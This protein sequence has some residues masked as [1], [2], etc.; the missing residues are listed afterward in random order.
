M[1]DRPLYEGKALA[2]P[3]SSIDR[4]YPSR[5]FIAYLENS[6]LKYVMRSKSVMREIKQAKDPDQIVEIKLKGK[7]LKVRMLRFLLDSGVEE[8]LVT[9]LWDENLGIQQ[10]KK[11]YF[12]RWGIETK[13][14]ELKNRLQI[15]NFTGD[16]VL[17][18]E[19]D[20]Y[21]SIYLSNMVALAK[22]EA[23]EEI[24]QE[25][26]SKNLKHKY[27]VN[28]NMLIGKLK[29][30]MIL[31]ILEDHPEKRHAIFRRIM[32]EILR[33]K[34]PVRPG[35]SYIRKMSLKANKHPMN[36]KRCL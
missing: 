9:N 10:F 6:S 2:L 8:V 4:G 30:T 11:L 17:S 5:D 20:F 12:R 31:L 1:G 24:A 22:N 3:E 27:Q 19:Q 34:V 23:N 29:D 13:Y 35:R 18:V 21:A 36:L 16:T 25:H 33:N 14:D 26:E 7:V 32:Q 28:T 15:Q